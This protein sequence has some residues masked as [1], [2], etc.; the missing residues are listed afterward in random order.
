MAV[1]KIQ[2]DPVPVITLEDLT[3]VDKA[4]GT[5]TFDVLMRAAKEHMVDEYTQGRIQ[6][7][8]YSTV[9]LGALQQTMQ[10]SIAF[11]LAKD[12]TS[13][14]L[15]LLQYQADLLELQKE[16]LAAKIKLIDAQVEKTGV[17]TDLAE[18]QKCNVAA[19]CEQIKT[20]TRK[21][22]AE[23]PLIAAQGEKIAIEVALA[24]LQKCNV[25]AECEQIKA[26]TEK[27]NADE[28]LIDAQVGKIEVE[29]ALAELQK[30][31]ITEEC[32][33][34]K[35]QT[36]K[37][38][39]EYDLIIINKTK[40]TQETEVLK[41][42]FTKLEKEIELLAQ[43]KIT[44]AAQVD[45]AMFGPDSV[46]GKQNQLYEAQK[47]GFF[48]KAEQEAASIMTATWNTRKMTD[49]TGTDAGNAGLGDLEIQKV[50]Q[51][52]QKGVNANGA[53]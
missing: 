29:V 30:C 10:Q 23:I 36:C 25:A 6:G 12:K 19:E 16:E 26:Q 24:E 21:I 46:I 31:V 4:E 50:I 51:V 45:G 39:A 2:P 3:T 40:A 5:G 38:K 17:E 13:Y 49:E 41:N 52:L 9:Y 7:A 33:Q 14:E 35:A 27:L 20:Q 11:L 43:K 15:Q 53:P 18:L 42:Q 32:E 47:E 8:E 44:E 1:D 48:R 28:K 37:L 34:V 22:E